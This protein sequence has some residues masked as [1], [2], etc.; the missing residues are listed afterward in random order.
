LFLEWFFANG[1]SNEEPVRMK[2]L[3]GE[4]KVRLRAAA[5]TDGWNQGRT[6]HCRAI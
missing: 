5:E 2:S 4:G 3:A 1:S 6:A